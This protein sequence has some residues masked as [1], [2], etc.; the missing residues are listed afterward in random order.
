MSNLTIKHYFLEVTE[1]IKIEEVLFQHLSE[2]VD[3]VLC[4]DDHTLLEL[5][6]SRIV[7][8]SIS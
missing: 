4:L 6:N 2:N 3:E 8:K 5:Y 7:E 1:R